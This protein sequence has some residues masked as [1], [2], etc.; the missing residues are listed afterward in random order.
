MRSKPLAEENQATESEQSLNQIKELERKVYQWI[1]QS[2]SKKSPSKPIEKEIAF[3]S[4]KINRVDTNQNFSSVSMKDAVITA[5]LHYRLLQLEAYYKESI[6]AE[7][8]AA[9]KQDASAY[10]SLLYTKTEHSFPQLLAEFFQISAEKSYKDLIRATVL[11]EHISNHVKENNLSPE[12]QLYSYLCALTVKRLY[13]EFYQAQSVSTAISSP[14]QKLLLKYKARYEK[15]LTNFVD[16]LAQFLAKKPLLPTYVMA[17]ILKEMQQVPVS[18]ETRAAMNKFWQCYET[19]PQFDRNQKRPFTMAKD[20]F[21]ETYTHGLLEQPYKVVLEQPGSTLDWEKILQLSLR[22][23]PTPKIIL[24]EHNLLY[25]T[26]A[27][28]QIPQEISLT[29]EE[30]KAIYKVSLLGKSRLKSSCTYTINFMEY[31]WLN[32]FGLERKNTEVQ[33]WSNNLASSQEAFIES[34]A[35]YQASDQT[36]EAAPLIFVFQDP[37]KDINKIEEV[38]ERDKEVKKI[39]QSHT[40]K[41]EKFMAQYL[42]SCERI[43]FNYKHKTLQ[44]PNKEAQEYALVKFY[45]KELEPQK[46]HPV[47]VPDIARPVSQRRKTLLEQKKQKDFLD[48]LKTIGEVEGLLERIKEKNNRI[49]LVGET[50]ELNDLNHSLI[51]LKKSLDPEVLTEETIKDLGEKFKPAYAKA[52]QCLGRHTALLKNLTVKLDPIESLLEKPGEV[53]DAIGNKKKEELFAEVEPRS[54]Q[55]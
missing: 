33:I 31:T 24:M 27:M 1:T 2:S 19:L 36:F 54:S 45:L 30:K 14:T 52:K 39:A 51:N 21:F 23:K 11:Q 10:Y 43:F 17:D 29:E 4:G 32:V 18:Q 41:V 7:N 25:L 22:Y 8:T 44:F 26:A 6:Y 50:S 35:T 34:L 5:E 37:A 3:L 49:T 42:L 48:S 15:A 16:E 9:L 55:K 20:S 40:D 47:A 13:V 46:P 28:R 53:L 12:M 38:Q